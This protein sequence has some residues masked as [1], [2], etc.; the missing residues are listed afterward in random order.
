MLTLLQNY[1]NENEI[2]INTEKTKCMT[3]TKS[4]QLIRRAFFLDGAQLENVRS[5]KYLG[6]VLTPC[7]EVNTGIKNL[8]DRAFKAFMKLKTDLGPSFQQDVTTSLFLIDTLIKPILIF[9]LINIYILI[10]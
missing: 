4:G 7:G 10:Q 2:K 3:F 8:R 6:F 9:Y 1:C 5:Y